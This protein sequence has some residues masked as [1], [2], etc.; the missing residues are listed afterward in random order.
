LFQSKVGQVFSGVVT[1]SAA[2]GLFVTL[3]D[4]GASGLVRGASATL[5]SRVRV[6]L[7]SVNEGK[8][9][10]DLSLADANTPTISH[11][12]PPKQRPKHGPTR[13]RSSKKQ[14]QKRESG[15]KPNPGG[16]A[17]KF[18]ERFLKKKQRCH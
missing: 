14:D 12:L 4:S 3:D 9:E 8:G 2:F 13:Q 7:E 16:N 11:S 6:R 17:P 5:G 15:R 18:Y 10:L 1:G